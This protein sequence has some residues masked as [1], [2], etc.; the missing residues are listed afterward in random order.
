MVQ[1][2]NQSEG[3]V[4]SRDL[5]EDFKKFEKSSYEKFQKLYKQIREDRKF[6][7]G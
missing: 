6:I 3:A 2:N 5:I 4:S 1:D 7:A